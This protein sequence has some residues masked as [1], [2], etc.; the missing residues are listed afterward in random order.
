MSGTSSTCTRV[1]PYRR[2]VYLFPCFDFLSLGAPWWRSPEQ[3]Y[4]V[5]CV[6]GGCR[7][8]RR[9]LTERF[10]GRINGLL[11]E[12]I[13][14][15]VPWCPWNARSISRYRALPG[16]C[17]LPRGVKPNRHDPIRTAGPACESRRTHPGVFVSI[18]NFACVARNVST[19]RVAHP[20]ESMGG[21]CVHWRRHPPGD[22]YG[23]SACRYRGQDAGRQGVVGRDRREHR[24]EAWT[25][26][27]VSDGPGA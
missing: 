3:R 25:E 23:S 26:A 21:P 11:A 5:R 22:A 24:S 14:V 10:Q 15:C 1:T 7:Q 6:F 9:R 16:A 27:I 17:L 18:D 8:A 12:M 2:R 4:G 20:M 19:H 13:R